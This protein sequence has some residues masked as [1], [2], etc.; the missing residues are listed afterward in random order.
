[1]ADTT[2][3]EQ[4]LT[5]LGFRSIGTTRGRPTWAAGVNRH[6]QFTLFLEPD[7]IV[8]TWRFGLGEYMLD[9]GW[10]IGGAESASQELYPQRDVRLPAEAASVEAEIRR[11][12]AQLHLDLTAP[13]L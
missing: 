8:L 6:L 12:L 9:R 4:E 13:D 3:L 11:T 10:Q 2:T 1:V 7:A 5:E